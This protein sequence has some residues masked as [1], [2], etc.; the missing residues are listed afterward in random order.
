MNTLSAG[1]QWW[2]DHPTRQNVP[3][4]KYRVGYGWSWSQLCV[5]AVYWCLGATHSY[6][7]ANDARAA[8][9][10]VSTSRTK[11]PTGAFLWFSL[12]ADGHVAVQ[13]PDGKIG[14]A[15]AYANPFHGAQALGTCDSI[16]QYEARSGGHYLG[17]SLDFGGQKFAP[18]PPKPP[19]P[20]RVIITTDK[21]LHAGDAP[22]TVNG[23]AFK[24][25]TTG[26]TIV[27]NPNGTTHSIIGK[28]KPGTYTTFQTDGNLVG[29]W[30]DA[31]GKR[32]AQWASKTQRKAAGGTLELFDNGNLVIFNNRHIVVKEL[33]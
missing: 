29:N 32:H 9:R 15:S 24:V 30:I 4:A 27:T 12:G 25:T 3:D 33:N 19:A 14:M 28:G 22:Y 13:R 7:T 8:S 6:L 11:I 18:E 10:I 21:P 5:A 2:L 26:L 16:A 20:D 17:Y 1:Q 31:K 23:Y